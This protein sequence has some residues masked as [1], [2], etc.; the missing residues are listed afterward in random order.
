MHDVSITNIVTNSV[1]TST[2]LG[3]DTDTASTAH[4][5]IWYA[6]GASTVSNGIALQNQ[7][8]AQANFVKTR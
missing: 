5:N 4:D 8:T 2:T 1:I 7:T 6:S 3:A